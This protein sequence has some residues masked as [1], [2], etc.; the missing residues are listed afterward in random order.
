MA[1]IGWLWWGLSF[2]AARGRRNGEA[3]QAPNPSAIRH[4]SVISNQLTVLRTESWFCCKLPVN[5][6]LCP[7]SFTCA[8]FKSH[9]MDWTDTDCAVQ[10]QT[11][12]EGNYFSAHRG[13]G[14]GRLKHIYVH[15]TVVCT[16]LTCLITGY[17]YA[18]LKY[19][20]ASHVW[21]VK[22]HTY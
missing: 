17:T 1:V 10:T 21:H 5:V 22:L 20:C 7:F 2:L 19:S 6:I 15:K 3:S 18:E 11:R 8:R 13:A 4:T 14:A 16:A 12:H 9:L